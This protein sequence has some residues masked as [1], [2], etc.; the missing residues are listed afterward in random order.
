MKFKKILLLVAIG[1]MAA[2]TAS[3]GDRIYRDDSVLP[4]AAKTILSNNFKSGVSIVKVEKDLGRVNEYE[5]VLTDGT[6]I[7]FDKNGNWKEIETALNKEVPAAL[8]P[9]AIVNYVKQN[10]KGT[11]VVGLERKGKGYEA[12][13]SNGVEMLFDAQGNFQRYDR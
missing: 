6:E 9:K 11:R 7:T 1:C 12:T 10:Q 3:A 8:I 2:F 13:L 4:P 5:V